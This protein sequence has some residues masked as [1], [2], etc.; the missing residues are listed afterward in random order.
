MSFSLLL[1]EVEK[2]FVY[3]KFTI[4]K[5]VKLGN[6][7]SVES[8]TFAAEGLLRRKRFFPVDTRHRFN[9]VATS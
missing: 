9:V 3:S 2:S 6:G 1:E 5:F 8:Y 4:F 7:D